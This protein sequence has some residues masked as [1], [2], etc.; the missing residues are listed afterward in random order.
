MKGKTDARRL[1]ELDESVLREL[2]RD[3]ADTTFGI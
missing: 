1:A 2:I 3:C